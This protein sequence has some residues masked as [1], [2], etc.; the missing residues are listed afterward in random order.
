MTRMHIDS[1]D[2]FSSNRK[3]S[4][5]SLFLGLVFS[6]S[7]DVRVGKDERSYFFIKPFGRSRSI[8]GVDE[9]L[10]LEH[11]QTLLHG[12]AICQMSRC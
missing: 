11:K 7:R 3:S 2:Y 5:F 9:A 12:F 8:I 4:V 1:T 10:L 6:S